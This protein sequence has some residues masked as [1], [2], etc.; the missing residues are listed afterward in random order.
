MPEAAKPRRVLILTTIVALTVGIFVMDWHRP[1]GL[2]VWAGYIIPLVV[3]GFLNRPRVPLLLAAV[4]SGLIGLAFVLAPPG[5]DP[6]TTLLNRLTGVVVLWTVALV[7]SQ[8][9]RIQNRLRES[10][11]RLQTLFKIL[12]AGVSLMGRDRK[13][14]GMNPALA[15]LLELPPSGPGATELP[16]RR[17]FL[18]A[19]GTTL[20]VEDLPSMQAIREQRVILDTEVGIIRK[21]GAVTWVT[22]NAAPL[23][24]VGAA[25]ALVDITHRKLAEKALAESEARYR[26]LFNQM[27]EGFA[28]HELLLDAAGQPSDCRFLEIN[29]AFERLTGLRREKVV[30]RLLTEVLPDENPQWL[31]RYGQ[32]AL[33][34]EPAHFEHYSTA[35]NR[36]YELDAYCPAPRQ[37]AVLFLDITARKRV[38]H[39]VQEQYQELENLYH[40]LPIGLGVIDRQFRFLK[41]ND[42]LAAINGRPAM[43]HLGRTIY[44]MIPDVAAT[45]EP[46]YRRVFHTGEAVCNL[47]LTRLSPTQPVEERNYLASYHPLKAGDGHV[48][49]ICSV[50]VDITERK[51]AEHSLVESEE[52]FRSAMQYSGIGMAI[53][54]PAGR[55]LEVNPVLCGILGYSWADLLALN[56]QDLTHPEDLAGNQA[57]INRLL[58]GEIETYQF[59]LRFRH[60]NGHLIWAQLNSSI[61][62][63]RNGKDC[64][65]VA[66]IQ[67]IT[68][69]KQVLLALAESEERFRSAMQYSAIGMALTSVTGHWLEVNPALSAILG[70]SRTEFLAGDFPSL[71][72]PDD[73]A[74][75]RAA[76][77]GLFR[78]ET[79]TFEVQPRLRHRDG[80]HLWVQTN[81]SLIRHNEGKSSCL[82][83]QMQ[84]VTERKQAA[85]ELFQSREMLRMILD[86]IPQRVFWK[87]A[88]LKFLG[89]NL[90]LARDC[91]FAS[92]DELIGKTDHDTHF[93]THAEFFQ[94]DDRQVILN[95]QPK[96]NYEEVQV[97]PNGKPAYL[98][99]SKVPLHDKDGRVIGILGTYEDITERKALET[100]FRQAQK[101]EAVGRLAG[102]VAHDFN[103]LLTIIAG[104]TN[105]LLTDLPPGDGSIDFLTEIKKAGD[106]AATLTRQLLAF[107][108]KQVL[109]SAILNL[110]TVIRDCESMLRRLLGEDIDVQTR[111]AAD[112]D[113]VQADAGQLEQVLLNLVVNARDAMPQGGTLV[114][115][116]SNA[117]LD[118]SQCQ[119]QPGL[120]PGPCVLLEVTDTGIGM[121]EATQSQIFEPFF[122]TKEPGKGTGLGLAMVFGFIKQSD[123]HITVRSEPGRGTTFSIYLP[124]VNAP[125]SGEQ[126]AAP[127]R[128]LPPGSETI[129]LVED[130]HEVRAFAR[131]ILQSRG[132]VVLEASQG[133]EALRLVETHSG[134]IHLLIS[135][136]VMP[137]MGGRQLAERIVVLRPKIKVLFISGYT[138]DAV[139]RH[140]IHA[141]ETNFLQK[142]FTSETLNEKVRQVLEP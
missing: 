4:F 37:C 35:L 88:S 63:Q 20:A 78:G 114:I 48:Y 50:L 69:R 118:E 68:S 33:S 94:A 124:Q 1:M 91:G 115:Q 107:S 95:N 2:A 60:Q 71:I 46:I 112:L 75:C 103:N 79:K 70:F 43:D 109:T 82:V 58:K 126:P 52:R 85:D 14:V 15:N 90:L 84:D 116:T 142:T 97:R 141:A 117:T 25:I 3:S 6:Q 28:L 121:D 86:H 133:G 137:G 30:G 76:M 81:V 104:Y 13:Y 26:R 65:L 49:G 36:H 53:V 17:R 108:R 111:L 10:E 40:S 72:H 38:E 110:N 128:V 113:W 89:A 127:A 125:A 54:L 136:V 42:R 66:Q 39:L 102:G 24:G 129:L 100:Q 64:H 62:W 138:D 139:M 73:L 120:K 93:R 12:P 101:M 92:P 80:R 8:R 7:E 140:G 47:E 55:F 34:G 106:H 32:V 19:D 105:I 87:D 132:Y 31:A 134:P 131:H 9:L 123:G 122:T 67:D 21:D 98:M 56:F 41:I 74:P 23:P 135:D 11:A 99:T 77:E 16:D 18:R 61:I 119:Q 130:Q 96:L 29:P 51:I 83:L 57:F 45:L 27:S 44:E 5:L 22:A 59:E